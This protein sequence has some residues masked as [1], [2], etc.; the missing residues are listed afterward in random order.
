[1]SS[2]PMFSSMVPLYWLVSTAAVV[3]YFTV[4]M[5]IAFRLA[6]W[7]GNDAAVVFA[8]LGSLLFGLI[9]WPFVLALGWWARRAYLRRYA[10]PVTA[11]VTELRHRVVHPTNNVI[12]FHHVKIAVEFVHP[13]TGVTRSMSKEF[14]FNQFR[15]R[16]AERLVERSPV[17]AEL[18]L[19]V[20][21]RAAG[22][23]V[24]ERPRWADI[25]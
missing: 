23:D 19:L 9:T 20:R 17:G 11:R 22:Y 16:T 18:P 15:R 24:P 13:A 25:W 4:T 7:S 5:D 14:A 6:R 10:T 12:S 3:A 1:M 2:R 8:L 21:G